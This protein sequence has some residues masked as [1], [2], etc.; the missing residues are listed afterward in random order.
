MQQA[1][2]PVWTSPLREDSAASSWLGVLVGIAI[3]LVLCMAMIAGIFSTWRLRAMD[4]L[5]QPLDTRSPVAIVTIDD[6]TLHEYGRLS[7]WSRT[8]YAELIEKLRVW[9]ARVI[10]LD[11]LLPEPADGD[12]VMSQALDSDVVLSAAG[13]GAPRFSSG[14][15]RFP[16]LLQP[17]VE[18][19]TIG[20]VNIFP[21]RDGVLR[22]L[23]L[24]VEGGG[25]TIPAMAWQSVA[26]YLGVETVPPQ[27]H[28]FTW[29]GREMPVDRSGQVI[30]RYLGPA[31]S[32]PTYSMLDVMNDE[33][34]TGALS[35]RIV[36]VGAT[37]AGMPDVYSVPVGG[38]MNGVEVQAQMTA[39]LLAGQ[40]LKPPSLIT[41]LILTVLMAAL[42][43]WSIVRFRPSVSAIIVIIATLLLL[44]VAVYLFSHG[45]L[46]DYFYPLLGMFAAYVGVGLWVLERE[47]WK[48]ASITSLFAGRA[49]PQVVAYLQEQARRNALTAAETRFIVAL[50]ADVRGYTGFTEREDPRRVQSVINAYLAAFAEAVIDAEGVVTKYVGD[51]VVALFNAPY[52]IEHPVERA[53]QAAVDGLHRLERLWEDPEMP[54][55]SMG[56]GINAGMAIVG[57]VGSPRR[58]DY[59]A[60]G[61]VVNV[62]SRLCDLAPAGEVYVTEAIVALLD[63][64]WEMEMVGSLALKGRREP[65]VTYRLKSA[66][67]L[68]EIM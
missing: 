10:V 54:R 47:R 33:L 9:G 56:V 39:A 21:D 14:V 31:G 7:S 35:G 67:A 52:H 2:A 34:P 11:I 41:T 55:L 13:L 50:F 37:A 17:V 62:A 28:P 49:S 63:E 18:G 24:W 53:L 58:Y 26:L 46:L 51:R 43:G 23:P 48:R 65:V 68:E 1:T 42:A 57:L 3:G 30:L 25:Y 20:H 60:L 36:F 5:Y 45:I 38:W 32:I 12:G 59:D 6:E 40:T 16:Y 22:K 27:S 66:I 4:M 19:G 61:D 15:V 8:R 44:R 29:A 64:S